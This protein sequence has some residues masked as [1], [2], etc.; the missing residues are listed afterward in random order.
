MDR[1]RIRVLVITQYYAPEPNFIT[2]D[3]A[4]AF[5]DAAFVTVITAHA[6]YPLGVFYDGRRHWFPTKTAEGPVTVWRVPMYPDHSR[7]TLRRFLSYLSFTCA[8]T[9]LAPLVAGAPR[10]VWIYQTPFT[11]AIAALWFKLAYRARLVFTYAD[12]W[13][14]SFVATAVTRPGPLV[15]LL[16]LSRRW[17]NKTADAIVGSTRGTIGRFRDDGI[18]AERLHYIPVWVQGIDATAEPPAEASLRIVYAGNIG[19]GQHL[20][21]IIEAAVELQRRN[22]PVQFDIYGTGL[23]ETRVRQFATDLGATNVHFHGRV[24]PEEAFR[25][26]AAAL[27]QLVSLRVDPMFEMTIPSKLPFCFAAGSPVLYSLRGEPA[28]V[29]HRSGG[30]FPFDGED[31]SSLV[32]CVL[33]VLAMSPEAR[34]TLRENL[35]Q[36]F[37]SE[38]GRE[39]LLKR[40][41]DLIANSERNRASTGRAMDQT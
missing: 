14:E 26:S 5:A 21:P 35:R 23:E 6:N 19:A 13:P 37:R 8:A 38:F 12:L 24:T 2:R 30:A 9:I 11:S 1:E 18:A 22:I 17:I 16:L 36:Y 40:Y 25:V 7:S 32:K 28:D 34:R 31:A 39:M 27:A 20:E 41:Q 15:N 4:H 33:D 29:A 3:V 10:V